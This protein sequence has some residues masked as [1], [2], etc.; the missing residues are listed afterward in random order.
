M[1]KMENKVAVVTGGNSG[2]GYASAKEFLTQGAKVIITGR[3][4]QFV[5]LELFVISQTLRIFLMFQS[6]LEMNSNK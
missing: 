3:N 2:I 5:E 6:N 1:K 4:K